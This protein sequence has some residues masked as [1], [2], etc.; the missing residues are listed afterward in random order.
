MVLVLCEMQSVLYRNWTRID[1][2]DDD[3]DDDL[4]YINQFCADTE[5]RLSVMVDRD[6]WWER[7]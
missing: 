3:D 2:D 6:G 7:I 5:C 1:D 4:T